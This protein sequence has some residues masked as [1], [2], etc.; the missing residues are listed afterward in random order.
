VLE[1]CCIGELNIG[2]VR[3]SA[4]TETLRVRLHGIPR[5]HMQLTHPTYI[6]LPSK[7]L[8]HRLSKSHDISHWHNWVHED[9]GA[10]VQSPSTSQNAKQIR[11]PLPAPSHL[12]CWYMRMRRCGYSRGLRHVVAGKVRTDWI[13]NWRA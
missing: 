12:G 2:L 5:V 4:V 7:T 1:A 8:Q 3:Y 10:H 6:R 11:L 9:K 13:A